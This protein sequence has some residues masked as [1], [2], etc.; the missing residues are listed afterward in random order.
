MFIILQKNDF[1][2]I[3]IELNNIEDEVK[4]SYT[5]SNGI[6]RS[7]LYNTELL[8]ETKTFKDD[9]ISFDLKYGTS[10]YLEFNFIPIFIAHQNPPVQV[11]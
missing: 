10:E 6:Y 11:I 2:K 8:L 1:S 9:L 3:K 5:W 4:F 7:I